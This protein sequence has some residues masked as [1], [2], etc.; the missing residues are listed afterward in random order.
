[1]NSLISNFKIK[2]LFCH[3]KKIES[4]YFEEAPKKRF[5]FLNYLHFGR[6]FLILI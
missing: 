5:F 2:Y 4:K 3:V 1:M 6:V